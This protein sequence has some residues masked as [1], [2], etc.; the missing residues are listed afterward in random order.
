MWEGRT[1]GD[2]DALAAEQL[3]VICRAHVNGATL[4][5][6]PPFISHHKHIPCV[7]QLLIHMFIQDVDMSSVHC[8]KH[9]IIKIIVAYTCIVLFFIYCVYI[10]IIFSFKFI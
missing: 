10:Y 1:I 3:I 7:H 2:H 9:Y 4:G 5:Q 8:P 6:I